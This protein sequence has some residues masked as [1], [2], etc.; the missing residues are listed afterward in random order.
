MVPKIKWPETADKHYG[1][2][3]RT[4]VYKN[5]DFLVQ[6]FQVHDHLLRMSV[7]RTAYRF[8]E[9]G[10]KTEWIDGITWDE[11]QEIKKS[12]GLDKYWGVEIYPPE[13]S[14]VNVANM[15]HIFLYETKPTCAWGD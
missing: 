1:V 14:V 12:V 8:K 13:K 15:R 6:I 11:L 9:C 10:V 7:N 4:L 5:K 3:Y 2:D